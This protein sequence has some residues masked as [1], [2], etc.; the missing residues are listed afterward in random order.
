[1]NKTLNPWSAKV[2][3]YALSTGKSITTPEAQTMFGNAPG[4]SAS[5]M[6]NSAAAAGY[7]RREEYQEEGERNLVTRVRYHA[8]DRPIGPPKRPSSYFHGLLRVRSIFDLGQL[9]RD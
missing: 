4:G 6:L 9:M 8:I 2:H 1:M 3:D 5:N 7:F